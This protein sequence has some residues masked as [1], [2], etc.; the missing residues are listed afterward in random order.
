MGVLVTTLIFDHFPHSTQESTVLTINYIW[1]K[2]KSRNLLGAEYGT[3]RKMLETK[4][5]C[6]KGYVT[7]L[8][9]KYSKM[10]MIQP[11]QDVRLALVSRDFIQAPLGRHDGLT[12]STQGWTKSL[13]TIPGHQADFTWPQNLNYLITQW[14]KVEG[15]LATVGYLFSLNYQS[16][17]EEP[18]TCHLV[19]TSYWVWF[20][21]PT[22]T[23][24][25]VPFT[26]EMSKV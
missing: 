6:L 19:S 2:N 16:G 24:T 26:H 15:P 3:G 14:V 25:E 10:W 12:C 4:L 8:T 23:D 21:R 5:P 11:S 13:A 20:H 1:Q 18:T 17:S 7:L 9:L 22:M